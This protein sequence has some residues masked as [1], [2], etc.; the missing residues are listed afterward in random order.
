MYKN[1]ECN[2]TN[3]SKVKNKETDYL[4]IPINKNC[5]STINQNN[6]IIDL[7]YNYDLNNNI[8]K[9][10][11]SLNEITRQHINVRGKNRISTIA[12]FLFYVLQSN[13]TPYLENECIR[14]INSII[15]NN[16]H[17]VLNM[18][19]IE[20]KKTKDLY[21][22]D[23]K[24]KYEKLLFPEDIHKFD[25]IIPKCPY[26]TDYLITFSSYTSALDSFYIITALLKDKFDYICDLYNISNYNFIIHRYLPNILNEDA[27]KFEIR[28][29]IIIIL[30]HECLIST[31][32]KNSYQ[33]TALL[34]IILL[35]YYPFNNL[36]TI[37][38]KKF[39]ISDETIIN[40]FKLFYNNIILNTRNINIIYEALDIKIISKKDQKKYFI[41]NIIGN[42]ITKQGYISL[43]IYNDIK[44]FYKLDKIK[45]IETDFMYLL[46][47]IRNIYPELCIYK[48]LLIL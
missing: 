28:K 27:A 10:T 48:D 41:D 47:L 46:N 31:L 13:R 45:L 36:N 29:K 43:D 34:T 26:V 3:V 37:L 2:N 7:L 14:I 8:I 30:T 9:S 19:K 1:M 24:K 18:K 44:T 16:Y 25:D 20:K 6:K 38:S 11:R 42:I 12:V 33:K 4:S 5:I 22:T 32:I 39:E 15:V 23:I 40:K 21:L 35:I 17:I